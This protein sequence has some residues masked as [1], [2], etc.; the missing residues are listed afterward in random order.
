MEITNN[1]TERCCVVTCDIELGETYWNN[2]YVANTTGWDLGQVSPP[3]KAYIDQLTNKDLRILIPGCG[4]TYEAEYLSQQGFSNITIID[5]ATALVETLSKKFEGD[6]NI[7]IIFGDFFDHMG[8]YDLI[9]EQTF[10]CAINPPLR[11]AYVAKMKELIATNGKLAGVLFDK[12][13]EHKGP[14]FGGC[15]CEYTPLFENDFNFKIF[16][17]CYNSFPKRKGT[18]LFFILSKEITFV[19]LFPM[20]NYCYQKG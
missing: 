3:L 5:I 19:T 14:P 12:E 9:L 15:K 13:F 4:N 18:E 16:E 17:L 8:E 11:K 2:Q 6:P 1:N 20:C 10:F 7:K